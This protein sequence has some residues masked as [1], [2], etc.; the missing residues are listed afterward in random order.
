MSEDR[1]EDISARKKRV[2]R[3][4][5]LIVLTLL[6]LLLLPPVSCVVLLVQMRKMD[7]RM[8]ELAGQIAVLEQHLYQEAGSTGEN[9]GVSVSMVQGAAPDADALPSQQSMSSVAG[10]TDWQERAEEEPREEAEE[11]SR[12]EETQIEPRHKVYLTFD[13]GPSIYTDQILDTLEEYDVKAT[14]FVVG[15]EDERSREAICRIVEDGHTLGMHSYSHKYSELYA[16]EENFAADLDKLQDY[17][18]EL[19]GVESHFYRFPGGSSNTVSSVSVQELA[20]YLDSRG[21]VFYDW[22]ISSGDGGGTLLSADTLVRNST[23]GLEERD[24][25]MILMHDSGDKPT[26]V[27]ALPAII[28]K[29]LAMEDTA[30]LPITE[31]TVPVQHIYRGE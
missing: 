26:T 31:D 6:I 8:D 2:K 16:S 7:A 11:D 14:F 5:R 18:Y 25:A 9:A 29:I 3:L 20:D 21:I 15:K 30:I 23:D 22:N 28:E 19:T 12:P 24:T 13:D 17:L 1:N 10:E 27:E 4:K